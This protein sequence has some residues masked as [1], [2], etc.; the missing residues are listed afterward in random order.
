MNNN[1]EKHLNTINNQHFLSD[2]MESYYLV[3]HIK[4]RSEIYSDSLSE[5]YNFQN[6]IM[7]WIHRGIR[8]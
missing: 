5:L 1:M 8:R 4:N 2:K 3:I 7:I 6:Q